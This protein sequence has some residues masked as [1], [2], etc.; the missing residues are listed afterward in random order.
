[1]KQIMFFLAL[2]MFTAAATSAQTGVFKTYED[3][4][5]NKMEKMDDEYINL[6]MGSL[7]RGVFLKTTDGK[8]TK[9]KV[10]EIWGFMYKNHVFRSITNGYGKDVF[11]HVAN[12]GKI[13]FYTNGV[14]SE[15]QL[16]NNTNF[17]SFDI[18]NGGYMEGVECYIS[19]DMN[20]KVYPMPWNSYKTG[21]FKNQRKRFKDFQDTYPAHQTLY[22]CIDDTYDSNAAAKCIQEYNSK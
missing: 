8:K 3:Y 9:F 10:D 11:A 14:A 7:G 4:V 1:M 16:K 6:S 19:A 18:S 12:S 22:T 2:F 5:A 17:G 20:S 15:Q 21:M 13:I